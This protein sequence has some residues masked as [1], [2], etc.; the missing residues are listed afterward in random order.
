MRYRETG[1][2]VPVRRGCDLDT[3]ALP[4][5]DARRLERLVRDARLLGVG[6]R[7]DPRGRDLIVYEI[8]VEDG[9]PPISAAFDDLTVPPEAEP[10]RDFLRDRARP[11]PLP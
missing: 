4:P 2:L 8:A 6:I 11:I 3:A 9:G 10:L 7:R 1:G 5:R